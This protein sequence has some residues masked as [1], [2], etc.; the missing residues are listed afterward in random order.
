MSSFLC[1]L[2]WLDH[3]SFLQDGKALVLVVLVQQRPGTT[4][5]AT[6]GRGHLQAMERWRDATKAL[7]SNGRRRWC[8]RQHT[9][10]LYRQELEAWT[11]HGCLYHHRVQGPHQCSGGHLRKHVHAR[12]D[13]CVSTNADACSSK[14]VI[15]HAQIARRLITRWA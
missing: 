12:L 8:T 2:F 15:L 10:C 3:Y 1:S 7:A 13:G 14:R 11:R 4:T 9:T 5:Q 6:A